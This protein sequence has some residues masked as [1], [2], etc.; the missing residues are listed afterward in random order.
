MKASAVIPMPAA[1]STLVPCLSERM[2]LTGPITMK[3]VSSG[4]R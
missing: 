3:P 2:P 1:A 4:R